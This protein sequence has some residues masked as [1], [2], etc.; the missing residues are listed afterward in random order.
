MKVKN[1]FKIVLLNVLA[2][3]IC[4][5]IIVTAPL[6]FFDFIFKGKNR[7]LKYFEDK[8]FKILFRINDLRRN[9]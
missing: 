3:I 7:I 8:V 9:T 1:R 2:I 5:A 6:Q 4:F